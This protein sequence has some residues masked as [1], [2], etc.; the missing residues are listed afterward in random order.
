MRI[1][2]SD[3]YEIQLPK[4]G[5]SIVNA[6]VVQWLKKEGE[7]ISKDEPLLEVSTDKVNSEI[8]S[9]VEGVI[10]QIVANEN[11]D[12]DVGG[13]LALIRQKGEQVIQEKKEP[14]QKEEKC[15]LKSSVVSPAIMRLIKQAGLNSDVIDQIHGS[16]EGGRV[17]R[18]DVEAF[19]KEGDTPEIDKLPMTGVRKAIADNMVKSFYEAPH[20]S[21]VA[22]IDVTDIMNLIKKEKEAFLK[23]EGVKLTVT[24]YIVAAIA[25][26][27]KNYPMV[28]ASVDKDTILLKRFVNLGIAV[29]IE[30]GVVVPVIKGADRMDIPDIAKNIASLSEKARNNRLQQDDVSEGTITMTNFGM[31]GMLMGVPIIRHPE[32]AIVGIGSIQKRVAVQDNNTFGIR[33]IVHATLTF[34][35]RIID[36]IYGANFLNAIKQT[37]ESMT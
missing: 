8:P 33:Q 3:L 36:G 28:N 6:T 26:A 2:M 14:I 34:D 1:P 9:P 19:I 31:S 37:L 29:S 5:E 17:T 10:D 18:R 15:A 24:S 13:L 21:L 11:D 7:S 27:T 16:G 35:H 23:K 4:L 32:V 20:A 12:V 22:E 25:K 30:N